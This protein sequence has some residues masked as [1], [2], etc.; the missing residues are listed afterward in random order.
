[1]SRRERGSPCSYSALPT[2]PSSA[3]PEG[4][5]WYCSSPIVAATVAQA[6]TR[7][8]LAQATATFSCWVQGAYLHGTSGYGHKSV[9]TDPHTA[10]VTLKRNGAVVSQGSRT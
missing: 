8:E 3:P 5:A 9:C 2:T 4:A 6:S 7:A 1:M 10:V